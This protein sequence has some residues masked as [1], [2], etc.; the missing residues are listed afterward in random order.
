MSTSIKSPSP[1]PKDILL[2]NKTIC[3]VKKGQLCEEC[4]QQH[5][6]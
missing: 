6:N 1:I 3:I 2:K 5:Y 4:R